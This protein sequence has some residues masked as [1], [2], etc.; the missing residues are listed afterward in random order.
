MLSYVFTSAFTNL[1]T[2]LNLDIFLTMNLG[3]ISNAYYF[4]IASEKRPEMCYLLIGNLQPV[5]THLFLAT[6]GGRNKG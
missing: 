2:V 6:F 4:K 5:L 3:L 1:V